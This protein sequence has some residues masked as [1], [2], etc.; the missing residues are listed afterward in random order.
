MLLCWKIPEL[1]DACISG[2][3]YSYTIPDLHDI[4]PR[5]TKMVPLQRQVSN[6]D[7]SDSYSIRAYY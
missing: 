7:I 6:Q 1:V 3:R 4:H 5:D 2:S